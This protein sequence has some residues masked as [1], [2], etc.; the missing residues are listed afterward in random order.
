MAASAMESSGFAREGE[1]VGGRARAGKQ[2]GS[3]ASSPSSRLACNV[4][5]ASRACG[6]HAAATLWPRSMW[7]TPCCLSTHPH[8][9]CLPLAHPLSR[10][11]CS[12]LPTPP[13]LPP[14]LAFDAA[15]LADPSRPS[16]RLPPLH[17]PDL[18]LYPFDPLVRTHFGFRR[19]GLHRSA[20]RIWFTW[21]WHFTAPHTISS[22]GLA[23]R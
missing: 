23:L 1:R 6:V 19:R 12:P 15:P 7:R 14:L 9:P 13:A 22:S 4:V 20:P 16:P 3:R 18:S 2:R 10:S 5:R 11:R 21:S 8:A 17:L